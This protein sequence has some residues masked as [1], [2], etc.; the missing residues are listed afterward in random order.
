MFYQLATKF[1]NS[2]YIPRILR[3]VEDFCSVDRV[4]VY[5]VYTP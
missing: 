1:N 3:L 4:K 2:N 5:T